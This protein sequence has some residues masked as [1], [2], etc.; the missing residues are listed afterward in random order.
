MRFSGVL[1]FAA[2]LALAGCAKQSPYPVKAPVYAAVTRKLLPATRQPDIGYLLDPSLLYAYRDVPG[3]DAL[4]EVVRVGARALDWVDLL[5]K[6]VPL[7]ERAQIW[8]RADHVGHEASPAAPLIYNP[9]LILESYR[10]ALA[11]APASVAEALQSSAPLPT[12]APHGLSAKEVVAAV[13]EVHTVYSRASRWLVLYQWHSSL[14]KASR[15]FRSWLKLDREHVALTALTQQWS[16]LTNEERDH[17]V[18]KISEVCPLAYEDSAAKCRSA[19]SGLKDPKKGDKARQWLE[20]LLTR[21]RRV[22]DAKFGVHEV[23]DGVETTTKGLMHLIAMPTYGMDLDFFTWLRER[24]TEGWSFKDAG[25][26][27]TLKVQLFDTTDSGPD[28]LKVEWENGALPHVNGIG[29]DVITMDANAPRWLEHTQ[30]VMRHEFGHI[31]GFLDCYTEFWDDELASF[32]YYA[33]DVTDA[34]CALSGQFLDRHRDALLRGY[35]LH[36]AR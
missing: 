25:G 3:A 8:R 5:Q 32:N 22:Y 21:G 14:T 12:L 18:G 27:Q 26:K 16:Q 24:V 30:T 20:I 7:A 13:R 28:A 2:A 19:F 9:D 17:F 1:L 10:K 33:L 29:G 31:L 35:F 36:T 4:Q 6:E 11:A 34:M 23:H 15:D